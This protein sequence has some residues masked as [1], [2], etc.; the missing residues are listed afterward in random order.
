MPGLAELRA[1][2]R[3]AIDYRNV[4]KG[5]ELSYQTADPKRVHA[6]HAWF[7]AQLSDHG[8]DAMEGHRHRM[9]AKP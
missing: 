2:R 1:A 4:E 8:A 5:G 6:L 3:N 9:P 7:D